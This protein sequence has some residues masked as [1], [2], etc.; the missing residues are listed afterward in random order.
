M[1]SA[2]FAFGS[3]EGSDGSEEVPFAFPNVWY[4][5]T[6]KGV[7]GLVI[8]PR[9]SPI[10]LLQS[11]VS[12]FEEPF[13]L[14]YVLVV[15]RGEGR[16]GRYQSKV[17][18]LEGVG[19][20]LSMFCEFLEGDGRHNLW[21]RSFGSDTTLVFDRHRVIYAYGSLDKVEAFVR[22]QSYTEAPFRFPDP[23]FHKYHAKY[24]DSQ[25]AVLDYWEW[26]GSELRDQDY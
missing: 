1:V 11:L 24:D 8:G 22:G 26:E 16:A 23:H 19:A 25:S 3:L 2:D 20:F 15:P 9:E 18:S 6:L 13:S 21:I 17:T 14:L 10:S 5:E 4:R 7:E 12:L